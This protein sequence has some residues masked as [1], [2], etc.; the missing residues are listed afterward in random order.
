MFALAF[1]SCEKEIDVN[2]PPS[3]AEWVVEAS[4]N[5]RFFS[6]NYVYISQTLDYFKPDL[7]LNGIKGAKVYIT[8]G[9]I[10]GADTV[11]NIA[12]RDSFINF[13]DSVFPGIYVN[14]T[15]TA[16]IGKPYLL[17]IFMPN[18]DFIK[19]K[20][21]MQTPPV[22]DSVSYNIIDTNAFVYFQWKDGPEQNNYRIALWDFPDSI[23]T[24]WG[25]ADRF[26]TLD[27]RFFDNGTRPFQLFNPFK[28]GDTL[29][30]YLSAIGRK[31][32]LFWDSYRRAS[33]NGGPFA[34]PINVSSNITGAIGSFTGYGIAFKQVI[35]K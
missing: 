25:A 17:E 10:F 22:I 35:F 28:V 4:I 31:E 33:G 20:T 7:S 34:T 21:F 11:F 15:F 6:L 16:K 27:D 14:P 24:G 29:N 9:D 19:G 23:L 26:Y 18:G 1:T 5:Q 8:E 13:F 3:K 30:I 32:Y 2:M 12:N